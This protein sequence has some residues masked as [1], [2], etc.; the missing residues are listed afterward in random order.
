MDRCSLPIQ[1]RFLAEA[2][3]GKGDRR[4]VSTR[5]GY[6]LP[7]INMVV[8]NNGILVQKLKVSLMI[9]A[10]HVGNDWITR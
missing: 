5:Q 3:P 7:V 9:I 10:L 6:R 8:M 2:V 4:M 1:D